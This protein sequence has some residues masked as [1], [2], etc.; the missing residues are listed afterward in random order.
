MDVLNIEKVVKTEDFYTKNI[1]F[2][3]QDLMFESIKSLE[4]SQINYLTYE[5]FCPNGHFRL[6][7]HPAW[8]EHYYRKELFLKATFEKVFLLEGEGVI[9]WQ[10][11]DR[12]PIYER[13]SEF[14]I[15]KGFT[16]FKRINE[17]IHLF[18]YGRS[19]AAKY[20]RSY[21]EENINIYHRHA[22]EFI[23]HKNDL[24][25]KGKNQLI[26]NFI[27]DGPLLSPR[28]TL[29]FLANNK[30]ANKVIFENHSIDLTPQEARTALFLLNGLYVK[31]VAFSLKISERMVKNY[32][33]RL[34]DKF[35]CEN[36]VQLGEKLS[37]ISADIF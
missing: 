23:H 19:R 21:D 31:Q 15:D 34:K 1:A 8:I 33:K 27:S 12:W 6:T 3:S 9:Y 24:I 4:H 28:E 7:S 22:S 35:H 2:K 30:F 29:T 11:I 25:S 20:Y 10:D 26:S 5:F 32:I 16:L 14:D 37:K 18:H 13:A 17:D 36:L